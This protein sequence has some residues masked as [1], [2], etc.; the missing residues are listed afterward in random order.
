M[1][2]ALSFALGLRARRRQRREGAGS[3][4]GVTGQHFF[5]LPPLFFWC[6]PFALFVP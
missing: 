1:S 4:D 5:T 6:P 2:S 3:L